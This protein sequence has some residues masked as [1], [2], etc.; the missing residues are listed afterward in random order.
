MCASS[1]SGELDRREIL[2]LANLVRDSIRLDP[3][4]KKKQKKLNVILEPTSAAS[5]HR[6]VR[7]D[8]GAVRRRPVRQHDRLVPLRVSGRSGARRGDQRVPRS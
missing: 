8:S 6:R 4:D 1:D 7:G 3:Y 5:R 2:H